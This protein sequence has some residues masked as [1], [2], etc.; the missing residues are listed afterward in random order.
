MRPVEYYPISEVKKK[1]LS[2][3]L[4]S[5]EQDYYSH[6]QYFCVK[7]YHGAGVLKIKYQIVIINNIILFINK[8]LNI[9]TIN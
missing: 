3:L 9:Q 1:K 5:I 8:Y 7:N 6:K 2:N 4:Y